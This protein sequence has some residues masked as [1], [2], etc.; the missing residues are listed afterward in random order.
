MSSKLV[1]SMKAQSRAR[2]VLIGLSMSLMLSACGGDGG[3]PAGGDQATAQSI[4]GTA[5]VGV[6][7][8]G[9]VTVKDAAGRTRT[10]PIGNNGHYTVDV[11]GL[12]A[13]FVFRA[14]GNVGGSDYVIHSAA[15][16][17]DLGGTINITPLTDLVL[18]NIAGQIASTYFD[19]GQFADVKKADLDAE[20]AKLKEKLLPMLQA[21]GVDSS[22]DL[23]RTPFTPLAS[24]LD[25]ALDQIRIS[26]DPSSHVATITNVVTQ[27]SIQDDIAVKA[28]QEASPPKLDNVDNLDAAS[29]DIPKIREALLAVSSKFATGLPSTGLLAPYL[30]DDFL[31]HDR[32]KTAFLNELVTYSDLVGSQFTNVVIESIDY[33]D[34]SHITAKVGFEIVDKQGRTT[35]HLVGFRMR[36]GQDGVWRL[37]G[38][39]RVLDIDGHVLA[40]NG[41][42][43]N[44]SQPTLCRSSG[45]TFWISD[46]DGSNNGGTIA[47]MI[48]RGPGLPDAGLRFNAP[49][50][51][52][53]WRLPNSD[54]GGPSGGNFHVLTGTCQTPLLFDSAIAALPANPS[55][56]LTAYTSSNVKVP[57]GDDDSGNYQ[58]RLRSGRPLT[59]A[60]LSTASFPTFTS[61]ASFAA[62]SGY[63]G[64]DLSV[65]VTG[66]MPGFLN[67]VY[68]FA[69]ASN[70]NSADIDR[71]VVTNS[72]GV[73]STTLTLDLP[74]AV[75]KT[76][77]V[78]THD[79]SGRNFVTA[80][81]HYPLP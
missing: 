38:D 44:G 8:Q 33:A 19:Q 45:F 18:A 39:Q 77:R 12:T 29:S 14:E 60:E 15:T 36:K 35:D 61:P 5:A 49:S 73:A 57:L 24:A 51:G 28:A 22:I 71:D 69:A 50:T 54:E 31:D 32:T 6:P 58:L 9:T 46:V 7:L 37:H 1:E 21:I 4:S 62:F 67:S 66:L 59:L 75:G 42:Y 13:P 3:D 78:S 43:A 81:D 34:P 17:A 2:L 63:A 27:Q 52:G 68:L 23:L 72:Q 79:A 30:S 47:Y 53:N 10:S 76:L 26:T 64:G 70:G 16:V 25:T 48:V 11:T 74:S 80:Y 40:F 65:T 56:T 55:Y 41:S 20:A